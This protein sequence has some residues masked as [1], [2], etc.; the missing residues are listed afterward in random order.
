MQRKNV[1]LP[2]PDGPIIA[3]TSRARYLHR[4]AFDHFVRAKTFH[5]ILNGN[6]LV[7]GTSIETE[8][9]ELP[10]RFSKRANTNP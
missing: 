6:H 1:L 4:N 9:A 2:P 10:A 3:S 8:F 7:S 5:E